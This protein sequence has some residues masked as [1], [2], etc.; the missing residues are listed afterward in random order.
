MGY[1]D[2]GFSDAQ[3]QNLHSQIQ[4]NDWEMENLGE[5]S[6]GEGDSVAC[7]PDVRDRKPK[8]FGGLLG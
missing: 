7:S 6:S 5:I 8:F 1:F 3:F 4:I 2:L